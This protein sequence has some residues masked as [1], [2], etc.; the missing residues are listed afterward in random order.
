MTACDI[1]N[2]GVLPWFTVSAKYIFLSC[3]G[4]CFCQQ[5]WVTKRKSQWKMWHT[6]P[7]RAPK[8]HRTRRDRKDFS[9]LTQMWAITRQARGALWCNSGRQPPCYGGNHPTFWLNLKFLSHGCIQ[10]WLNVR[11]RYYQHCWFMREFFMEIF[12]LIFF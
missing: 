12:L 2:H 8:I 7:I 11:L 9:S 6:V 5:Q 3:V 4:R 1:P 10:R